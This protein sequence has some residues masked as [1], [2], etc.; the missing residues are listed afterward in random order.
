LLPETELLLFCACHA[1]MTEFLIKPVLERGAILIADR[2]ADST[3]VYQGYARGLS[4]SFIGNLDS[5]AC[6]GVKPDLTLLLD[7]SPEA[8]IQ[9]ASK[10]ASDTMTVPADRFDSETMDF[11]A[12]IRNGF[13]DIAVRETERIKVINAGLSCEQVHNQIWEQVYEK[14]AGF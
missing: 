7:L 5:F 11:H 13:L 1:Q 3:L 14:L 8:G 12:K 9:R 6:R 2:F 10:R 4:K